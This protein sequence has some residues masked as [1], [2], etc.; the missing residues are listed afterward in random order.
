VSGAENGAGLAEYRL[1]R[2]GVKHGAELR[3]VAEREQSGERPKSAAPATA[4]G[5]H[6]SY[7]AVESSCYTVQSGLR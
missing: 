3:K 6:L 5:G 4:H 1:E 7:F 2:S